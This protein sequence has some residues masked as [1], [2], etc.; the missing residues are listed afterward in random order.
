MLGS[1][2]LAELAQD[3]RWHVVRA[4]D[5]DAGIE[6]IPS[7]EVVDDGCPLQNV[8]RGFRA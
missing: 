5:L 2:A 3:L 4:R 8:V 7:H 6:L 1:D